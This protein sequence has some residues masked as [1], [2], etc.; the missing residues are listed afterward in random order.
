MNQPMSPDNPQ[1]VVP[2]DDAASGL[3]LSPGQTVGTYRILKQV[4]VGPSGPVFKA[5]ALSGRRLVALKL[6][7]Q[8]ILEERPTLG[9]RIRAQASV[10]R[11]ISAVQA[12][13]LVRLF[14]LI[15]VPQGLLLANEFVDGLSLEQLLD[16]APEPMDTKQALGIVA[17]TALSLRSLHA[18]DVLHQNLKPANILLPHSGGLKVADFGL[19]GAKLQSVESVRYMAPELL[20]GERAD[21]RTDLYAL[22]VV[23]YEM[24]AGRNRFNQAFRMVLRDR[25]NQ[26]MRWVKWHTNMRT[27]AAAL[28]DLVPD[29]SAPVCDLVGRLMEFRVISC[30]EGEAVV[31]VPHTGVAVAREAL[32]GDLGDGITGETLATSGTLKGLQRRLAKR[33]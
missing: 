5:A 1:A 15:E 9:D 21:G 2:P 22:G 8:S 12:N 17:A 30:A 33:K 14:E 4:G 13:H 23:A 11:R 7:S 28:A 29:L 10:L 6:I 20:R 3:A 24:L 19:V 32:N 16:K 25:R 26:A 18:Q 27:S 31:R